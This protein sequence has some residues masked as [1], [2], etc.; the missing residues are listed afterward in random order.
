MN[1]PNACTFPTSPSR[2][3]TAPSKAL[4]RL[5]IRVSAV[6]SG[7][8]ATSP[9]VVNKGLVKEHKLQSKFADLFLSPMK[10]SMHLIFHSGVF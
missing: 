7:T 4:M 5:F 1:N 6:R 2:L 9:W 10:V 8:L 3:E